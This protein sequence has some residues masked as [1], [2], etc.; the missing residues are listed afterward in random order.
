MDGATALMLAAQHGNF[1]V[2]EELLKR[3]A[4]PNLAA[5]DHTTALHLAIHSGHLR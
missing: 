3:G 1:K 2:V 4:N 5:N